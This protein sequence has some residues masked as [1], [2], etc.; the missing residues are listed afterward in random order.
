MCRTATLLDE[1]PIR[2][3]A[4]KRRTATAYNGWSRIWNLARYTNRS[5]YEAAL[6]SLNARHP[7]VLDVGCGTGIMS[8]KLAATGRQVLGVDLSTAMVRRAR[9]K[10][11]ANLDFMMGDAEQLPVKDEMFDAVVNLISFHHYPHPDRALAEFHRVLRPGG[12]LVLVIFDRDSRYITL[13]QGVNR[14]T[15]PFAGKTWQKTADEALS[16]VNR[17]GFNHIKT[18]PVPYWIKTLAIVAERT[19][20]P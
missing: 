9:R 20:N 16:L 19:S 10:R 2:V 17:A 13:A 1:T 12:R 6:A 18:F 4:Y 14:W 8:A 11:T 7:R 15:K 3:Q 5:I